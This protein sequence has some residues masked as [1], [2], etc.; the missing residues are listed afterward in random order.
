MMQFDTSQLKT[1]VVK[2]GTS[3]ISG[4]KAFEG[5]VLEA[6]VKEIS[7]LKHERTLNIIIVS[8]GAIGCG[9]N[10]MG[11]A[12]RP[13]SLPQK[14]AIAAIGQAT[15]VHYYETLFATHG[16]DLHTAQILLSERDL[17]DRQHYLNVRN[18]LHELFEMKTVIPIVNENDTTAV[19]ELR[20]GDN[21]TLAAKI[22]AKCNAELL[23]I[24]S[25]VNGLY[26]K[27]PAKH[28]DATLITRVDEI[29]EEIE[30]CAGGAGTHTGTGGMRTKLN[31]A[32]IATATGTTVTI[33]NGHTPQILHSILDGSAS[34][35]TFVPSEEALS[36]FKR[37]IAYGRTTK[38][39]LVVDTG[40][41]NALLNQGTSLLA[42]GISNLDGHFEKGDAVLIQDK[43]G[44]ELARALVN[45]SSE[46]LAKIM[47]KKSSEIEG[48]LGEKP[49]NE[50]AHRDNMVIL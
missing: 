14:Q 47:G 11:M 4:Q 36:H 1:L 44:Q 7:A 33:A 6:M 41:R 39:T 30:A 9:M 32:H 46:D 34:C 31:A 17:D 38:G 26:D 24:L 16:A 37:W 48:I 25:D 43:A 18:T 45:Y 19:D 8:S 42:V 27:N 13:S 35:T 29:T 23:I 22:A 15:L 50:V 21:D 5:H 10:S 20:F 12:V 28:K 40:A 49:Y 2:I 3:L